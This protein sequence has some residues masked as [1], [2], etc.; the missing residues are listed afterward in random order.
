MSNTVDGD[1]S[2]E[3][4]EAS[5]HPPRAYLISGNSGA[6]KSTLSLILAER[7]ARSA[8]IDGD[9]VAQMIVSGA[10]PPRI[11]SWNP[12]ADRFDDET[13]RQLAL[14][15]R[16]IGGMARRYLESG[17]TVVIDSFVPEPWIGLLLEELTGFHVHLVTIEVPRSVRDERIRRRG[18][19]PPVEAFD[20]LVEDTL[21]TQPRSRGLWL[22][23]SSMNP[24]V[25][26]DHILRCPAVS[27][28]D[29]SFGA[30]SR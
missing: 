30:G 7:F 6:G 13:D 28:L 2:R 21:A 10:R 9:L 5:E 25:L 17:F 26:A 24:E 27:R 4:Q 8:C 1:S 16:V 22:D 23:G 14:R 20:Q 18:T 11:E 12:S 19:G 3:W 29:T 15:F